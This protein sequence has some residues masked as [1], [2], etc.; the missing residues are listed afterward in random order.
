MKGGT[1]V[2]TLGQ[3]GGE[4]PL[5][6]TGVRSQGWAPGGRPGHPIPR[7]AASALL[8]PSDVH[9]HTPRDTCPHAHVPTRRHTWSPDPE[10]TRLGEGGL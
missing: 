9:M 6:P 4:G 3:V 7:W 5:H 1:R 8:G 10:A 2:S